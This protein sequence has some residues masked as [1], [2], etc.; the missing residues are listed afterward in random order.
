MN[1]LV[2]LIL[3]SFGLTYGFLNRQSYNRKIIDFQFSSGLNDENLVTESSQY[4]QSKRF[5]T[6]T[7]TLPHPIN[8][9]NIDI[10]ELQSKLDK[11][12]DLDMKRIELGLLLVNK[13]NII[14][15]IH[16]GKLQFQHET[17]I[18][19]DGDINN[20][21]TITICSFTP[22]AAHVTVNPTEEERKIDIERLNALNNALSIFSST[23]ST[24]LL[25]EKYSGTPPSRI[26]R[27]FVSPR[28]SAV[29]ILEPIERAANRTAQ[30]IELAVRQ[31]RAD[32]ASYLRNTDKSVLHLSRNENT[33]N[34]YKQTKPIV[35]VLDNVRSAFNVGSIY[36]TAET[37][38]CRMVI[39][40]GITCHP[41]NPKLRKTAFDSIDIVPSLHFDDTMDAI[42][43]LKE[44]GYTIVSMETT[45]KSISYSTNGI[46]PKSGIALVAGNEVFGV[47]TN[48][49]LTYLIHTYLLTHSFQV[50]TRVMDSCD[51]IV[52][53]KT[54]GVKN[55]LN[56]ASALPIVLF[57]VIRQWENT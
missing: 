31:I 13:G 56:V 16:D 25:S 3:Y 46:Y 2:L 4:L 26:Y 30:Q 20:D 54:Y 40:C 9:E 35:L 45:S 39:T 52:E 5:W 29:H 1:S 14:I 22:R 51:K 43:Y 10:I 18:A 41:P 42:H 19:K 11:D 53:I 8:T 38:G 24:E 50:D 44:N 57:E 55:S 28:I 36:R 34:T 15:P 7:I 48:L 33:N 12:Y 49:I 23:N 27:S 37:A 6:K 32:E 47:R 21:N 17:K